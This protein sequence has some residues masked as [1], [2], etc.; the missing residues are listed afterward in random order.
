M[1]R[2][3]LTWFLRLKPEKT[4]PVKA[5]MKARAKEGTKDAVKKAGNINKK[6]VLKKIDKLVEEKQMNPAIANYLKRREEEFWNWYLNYVDWLRKSNEQISEN[7]VQ[8]KATLKMYMKWAAESII[9]TKRMKMDLGNFES[10]FP[11]MFMRY[12]PKAGVVM[13]YLFHAKNE[14]RRDIWKRTDP[15]VPV[16]LTQFV[17]TYNPDLQNWK[18][19]E[20][21]ITSHNGA[22]KIN[23]VAAIANMSN[24]PSTDFVHA[25][26]EEG[27]FTKGEIE[28]FFDEDEIKELQN[29]EIL[30]KKK[31][32][33]ENNLAS[34]KENLLLSFESFLQ[35][36]GLELPSGGDLFGLR[37][38]L[39]AG[40][41]ADVINKSIDDFKRSNGMLVD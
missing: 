26:I 4:V 39:A 19:M 25:M 21:M 8:Q 2:M 11:D 5:F 13:E 6:A 31:D 34:L 18:F 14:K 27:A 33:S 37:V 40:I 32:K 41:A 10:R 16:V 22:M 12:T 20:M 30:Y 29:R 24:N 35:T 38:E 23:D 15:W 7:L 3:A 17:I 1:V 28:S 9:H 36:F